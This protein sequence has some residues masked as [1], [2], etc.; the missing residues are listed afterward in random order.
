M[1]V[2]TGA[3]QA[4]TDQVAEMAERVRQI[5]AR[6]FSLEHMWAAGYAAGEAAAREAMPGRGARTSA[7]ASPRIRHLRAGDGGQS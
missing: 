1:N 3:F 2:D 5:A 6:D 4:L 7:A